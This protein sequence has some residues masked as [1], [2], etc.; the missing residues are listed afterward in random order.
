[1]DSN[2][3]FLSLVLLSSSW[4]FMGSSQDPLAG[5]INSLTDAADGN[6][7]AGLAATLPLGN[8]AA[9]MACAQKLMPCQDFIKPPSQPTDACCSPL[10]QMI[11]DDPK[12]LCNIFNNEEILKTFGVTQHEALKLLIECGTK[13]DIRQC[14]ETA[15]APAASESPA[16]PLPK[17]PETP[18]VPSSNAALNNTVNNTNGTAAPAPPASTNSAYSEKISLLGGFGSIVLF[19]SLF[20]SV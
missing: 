17:T 6:G 15:S 5:L 19:T 1:M 3:L 12:C 9:S 18:T 13:A 2:K 8:A 16:A 20:I 14:N 10:K 11:H 7:G 4:V